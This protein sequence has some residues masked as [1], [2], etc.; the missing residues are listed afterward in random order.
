MRKG[1][2]VEVV[3]GT[4][5]YR[6]MTSEEREAWHAEQ[7]RLYGPID[8]AGEPWVHCG[9]RSVPLDAG[10]R[11]MV[12]RARVSCRV[13]W[14]DRPGYAYA[15]VVGGDGVVLRVPRTDVVGVRP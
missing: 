4:A 3:R 9:V 15:E 12:L 10:T 11:F 8:S 13:T 5:G 2:L 6:P 1:E 14:Y 7:V